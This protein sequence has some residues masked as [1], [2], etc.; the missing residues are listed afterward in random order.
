[1]FLLQGLIHVVTTLLP[2]IEHRICARHIYARWAKKHH[3][4]DL[5]L[6]FWNIAR[7]TSHPEMRKHLDQMSKL[8][9]VDMDV[10]ELL[11]NWYIQGWCQAFFS[12]IVKCE[13]VDNNMCETF[14]GVVLEARSKPVISMLEDI[15]QYVMARIAM[16]RC[17]PTK[18]IG[19]FIPNT[20]AKIE[21]ERER[22]VK[23]QC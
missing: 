12:D 11:E 16:K 23:W 6:Q 18:W 21:K 2:F 14:N 8:K 3:G 10:Q 20:N 1:M 22:S 15:R 13:V 19:N 7:S 9:G 4:K 5:Q 17:Y